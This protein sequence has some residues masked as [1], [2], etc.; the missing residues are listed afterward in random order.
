LISTSNLTVPPAPAPPNNELLETDPDL[1]NIIAFNDQ[2]GDEIYLSPE[3]GMVANTPEFPEELYPDG[4]FFYVATVSGTRGEFPY[5]VGNNFQNRP[6]SQN[7]RALDTLSPNQTINHSS[8]TQGISYEK[9]EIVFDYNKL[10]RFRNPYL[11]ETKDR[12]QVSVDTT[13]LGTISDVSVINGSPDNS[14][15]GDQLFFDNDDTGGDF[16]KAVVS[17]VE[18]VPVENG[19]GQNLGTTLISHRQLID[20][21]YFWRDPI[22]NS[23]YKPQLCFCSYHSY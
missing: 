8:Y 5:I 3:N 16:A 6:I 12:L 11:E 14:E 9:T 20:L 7:V 21:N 18:G 23:L 19:V 15:V 13:S 17:M 22:S 1:D 10:S 4:I 2:V